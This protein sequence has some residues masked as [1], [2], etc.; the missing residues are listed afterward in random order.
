MQQSS[1][2]SARLGLHRAA[3]RATSVTDWRAAR[4]STSSALW[5]WPPFN[6]ADAT[7]LIG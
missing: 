1:S 6:L 7:M 4:S 5:S 2:E 3:P